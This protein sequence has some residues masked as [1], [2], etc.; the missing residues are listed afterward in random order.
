VKADDDSTNGPEQ[1]QPTEPA[2]ESAENDAPAGDFTLSEL[3]AAHRRS[4]A[5]E[6]PP[7]PGFGPRRDR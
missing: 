7:A 2:Q 3:L 5:D 4:Q 1:E 6:R